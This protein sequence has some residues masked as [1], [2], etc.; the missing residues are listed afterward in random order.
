MKFST[1]NTI[2][3]ILIHG[4]SLVMYINF[5]YTCI[6][7]GANVV[8]ES[9]SKSG[10]KSKTSCKSARPTTHIDRWDCIEIPVAKSPT[11]I[12]ISF[13]VPIPISNSYSESESFAA[14]G[15]DLPLPFPVCHALHWIESNWVQFDWKRNPICAIRSCVVDPSIIFAL[16]H[17]DLGIAVPSSTSQ[18]LHPSSHIP[19]FSLL[20]HA[21]ATGN[22][23]QRD[24]SQVRPPNE[25]QI[26][27]RYSEHASSDNGWAGDQ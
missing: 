5:K 25:M 10:N 11:E 16:S 6:F 21:L 8:G 13:S 3:P 24:R 7:P 18:N 1:Q 15:R 27:D 9:K 19:R 14:I 23:L 20:C 26:R 12:S 2:D 17:Q 22:T 4:L